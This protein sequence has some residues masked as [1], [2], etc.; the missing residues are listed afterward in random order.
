MGA[1][2]ILGV[3]D[4]PILTR[5]LRMRPFERDDVERGFALWSDPEVGRF[6][7]GAHATVEQSRVLIDHHLA[8]QRRHGY[9]LWAVEERGDPALIGE[10]GLQLIEGRGPDVEIGWAFGPSA[11]GHG[12][13]TE[14]A[15]AWI[16][17]AFGELGIDRLVAVIRPENAASHRV[18]QRLG[19]QPAGRRV[20]Y[21]TEHD[22]YELSRAS[23][24]R[25]VGA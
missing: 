18:A 14:A 2:T 25:R 24:A 19:M 5:R 13:A 22:V 20:A 9:S 1:G 10:V 23:A 16:D 15:S 12:Y 7:G 11:W 8:H 21:G 3:V 6:T 17:A 4:E